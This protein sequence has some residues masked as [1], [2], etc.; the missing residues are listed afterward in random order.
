MY[1]NYKDTNLY[2]REEFYGGQRNFGDYEDFV[3]VVN[4][5]YV[6]EVI[7][8]DNMTIVRLK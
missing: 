4:Y 2:D 1:F 7:V 3:S 5:S 8:E 6:G